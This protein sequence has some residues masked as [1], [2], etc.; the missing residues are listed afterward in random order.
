VIA[1]CLRAEGDYR[2]GP[3]TRPAARPG[4]VVSG[5]PQ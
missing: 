2:S 4:A 3:H 1:V 5:A